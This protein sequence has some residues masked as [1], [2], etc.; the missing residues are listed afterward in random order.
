MGAQFGLFDGGELTRDHVYNGQILDKFKG[1]MAFSS[2]GDALG[3]PTEFGRYP[4]TVLKQFGK[5]YLTDFVEW[6]KIVG[7]RYW[8]Y[9]EKIGKGD[10]SDDTQLT[11]SVARSVNEHGDFQPDKFAYF[12]LPFWLSYERGGGRSIKTAARSLAQTR[13]GWMSNFYS[14]GAISYR[15]AGA[16]GAA[17]R[18]LPIALVNMKDA[19]RLYR[20]AFRNSIVTHGHPRA[21]LGSIIYASAI[22]LLLRESSF[23]SRDL[24][25]YLHDVIAHSSESLE[26]HDFVQEWVK[27]WD[28]TP[29]NGVKF[30]D[31]F[32][33]TKGEA[34]KY[35]KGISQKIDSVDREYYE[36]TGALDPRFRGSAIS[37]VL[38]GLYLFS[39][40]LDEPMKA[41]LAA[42]N[43]LASDTDTIA[44]FVGG[45]FGAR[46][47]LSV[48]PRELLDRLQ[49]RQYILKTAENLHDIMLGEAMAKSAPITAFDRRDAFLQ[50]LAWEIGLHEMFWDALGEGEYIVHPVLGRGL[51][52]GKERK[53]IQR[54]GYEVKLIKVSFDC[55]QTCIFH[56]RI[57]K[58]GMLSESLSKAV[59]QILVSESGA[60]EL[61]S[62]IVSIESIYNFANRQGIVSFLKE[63]EFIVRILK[64]AH[65]NIETIFGASV[66][67]Y[68][69]LCAD[70]EEDFEEL[71]VVIKST[72]NSEE[73]LRLLSKL[74]ESWFLKVVD[75]TQGKLNITVE[76]T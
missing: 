45:L 27:E 62:Q 48:V 10:Y 8:G 49:D 22:S 16:N 7:G 5:N 46:Y 41:I 72:H 51:I 52:A 28:K 25:E 42:V 19:D 6:E 35:L 33:K 9:R 63:N 23:R 76:P 66:N 32:E 53:P 21:I 36:F 74:D 38:V 39:K 15:N 61:N 44:N 65:K 17:M 64:E 60:E 18:I 73:A 47:G 70:P 71:F 59:S 55:G 40:Y 24:C 2:V 58:D 56:H 31:A 43:M 13:K 20:D 12:E 57:A 34:T 75:S 29:L 68:L 4:S 3:W 67:L 14:Q 54:A 50:I 30:K 1:A 37:T 26:G 11:L 69:K